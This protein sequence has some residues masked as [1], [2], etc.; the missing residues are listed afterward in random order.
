MNSS[1]KSLRSS[2]VCARSS[3]ANLLGY[4]LEH[5]SLGLIRTSALEF[6][7]SFCCALVIFFPSG[8]LMLIQHLVELDGLLKRLFVLYFSRR[9][10]L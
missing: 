8:H 2:D 5:V 3:P 7:Q 9:Y 1:Q 4:R 10:R 6:E